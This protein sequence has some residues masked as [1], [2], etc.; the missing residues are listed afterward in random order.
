MFPLW[1][2]IPSLGGEKKRKF[3]GN[4]KT[5]EEEE[6][7]EMRH[8]PPQTPPCAP[9]QTF[10]T[11]MPPY[12]IITKNVTKMDICP[13]LGGTCKFEVWEGFGK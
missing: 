13:W 4:N 2:R 8:F 6:K 11:L 12:R 9:K 10:G 5:E 3:K 7:K 1:G